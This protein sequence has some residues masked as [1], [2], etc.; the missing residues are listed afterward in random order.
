MLTVVGK[1]AGVVATF[2]NFTLAMQWLI[3]KAAEYTA[4]DWH[5]GDADALIY[6][7]TPSDMYWVQ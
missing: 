5:E 2:D 4:Y 7:R 1:T 6:L 3:A